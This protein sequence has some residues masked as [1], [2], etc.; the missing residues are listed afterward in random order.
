MKAVINNKE[1][2]MN[3]KHNQHVI[4][5]LSNNNMTMKL[6]NDVMAYVDKFISNYNKSC[7]ESGN[8][9]EQV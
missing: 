7:Y 2:N 8:I 4:A 1:S 3:I 5:Y 6:N 9:D